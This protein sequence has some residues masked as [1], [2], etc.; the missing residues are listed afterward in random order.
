[1]MGL[2]ATCIQENMTRASKKEAYAADI[3]YLTAKEAGF[4]FLRDN[5]CYREQDRIL[6]EPQAAIVDEAD[7]ILI[8]E[9]RI[10]LVIA[11]GRENSV[12]DPH[13]M[14]TVVKKFKKNRDYEIDDNGLNVY[15]TE[16][17]IDRA[18]SI[19]QCGDLHK[20][21]NELKLAALN[22]A[23]HAEV[24][25][26]RDVDYILRNGKIEL[27]DE[28]TGRVADKRRWPDG[29]QPAVEAKEDVFIQQEG[30][31]LGS[32][33]LQHFL[34][35]YPK[36][37]GMTAT[38]APA[39]DEFKEVYGLR[40]VVIPSHKHCIRVDHP[41][42]L[43]N[44]REEKLRALVKEVKINH[45]RSRPILVGT[46][47]VRESEEIAGILRDSGLKCQVLNAKNDEKEAKII[48]RAGAL[49][50]I[51]ISTN[52]AG[53]GTDIRLGGPDGREEKEVR[54][55]GGLHVIGTNRHESL[56]ID[57]QLRG[58]AG[59]QGDPGSTRFFVCPQDDLIERYHLQ[60]LFQDPNRSRYLNESFSNRR[61]RREI[62]RAQRIVEAQNSEIRKTLFHY[63]QIIER[64]RKVTS[65][66]RQLV[67]KGDKPFGF[68]TEDSHPYYIQMLHE[69]NKKGSEEQVR[70]T[71]LNYIDDHW[72]EHLARV[73]DIREGVHLFRLS[74]QIPLDEYHKQVQD[75]FHQMHEHRGKRIIKT[76]ESLLRKGGDV[77]FMTKNLNDPASTWTYMLNDNPFTNLGTALIASRNIGFAVGAAR[78]LILYAPLILMILIIKRI[79]RRVLGNRN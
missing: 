11:G 67:L 9:A 25:L 30:K 76:L 46:S 10:P 66:L 28:F 52:M 78:S 47:S 17:G 37:C 16:A 27:I 31:I 21:G 5:L 70:N 54:K 32:I 51:T 62:N 75:A 7:F 24:L 53:R 8:D 61:M 29:I 40:T 64:Q 38:A 73:A 1:M 60:S 13:Y 74:G 12:I 48:A 71:I 19:I 43:Y 79:R 26:K 22:L 39:A 56:R 65:R 4:D 58:R 6:P 36:I 45:R 20:Q 18:E 50:A 72:S 69:L 49:K 15:M 33:T 23:L 34:S 55:L 59:R 57:F 2:R 42:N 41:D 3:T 68:P 14:K 35:L 77:E 44:T 63:S